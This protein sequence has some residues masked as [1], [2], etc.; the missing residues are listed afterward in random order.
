MLSTN[1]VN[2]VAKVWGCTA[3]GRDI[4]KGQPAKYL[5]PF[6][7]PKQ[8]RHATCPEWKNS[9]R[10]SNEAASQVWA[11]MEQLEEGI[12]AW[13]ASPFESTMSD[14]TNT[15]AEVIRE[16]ADLRR[17]AATNLEEGFGHPTSQS[18]E[19][20]EKGDEY[21]DWADQLEQVGEEVDSLMEQDP[22]DEGDEEE[23]ER[24]ISELAEQVSDI[25]SSIDP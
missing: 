15:A 13:K 2:R 16:A 3:C 11:A 17:E 14:C 22:P 5:A 10:E 25:L 19:L 23:F 1:H 24:R 9:E 20:E 21:D 7:A 18:E 8:Y 12:E 6:R 4:E